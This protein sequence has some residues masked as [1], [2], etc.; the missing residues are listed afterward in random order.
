MSVAVVTGEVPAWAGEAEGGVGESTEGGGGGGEEVSWRGVCLR[1]KAQDVAVI[2]FMNYSYTP[3]TLKYFTAHYFWLQHQLNC[4]TYCMY[5]WI[6]DLKVVWFFHCYL[7]YCNTS[8]WCLAHNRSV[9]YWRKLWCLWHPAPQ[10][11]PPLAEGSCPPSRSLRTQLSVRW[12]TGNAS[13]NCW[14]GSLWV[15]HWICIVYAP[16]I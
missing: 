4:I 15:A 1:W 2:C 12:L 14:R 5:V 8:V 16:W 13:R 10:P 7:S 11:C 6:L 3:Q 9:G